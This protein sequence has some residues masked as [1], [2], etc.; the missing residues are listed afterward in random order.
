MLVD[1]TFF[2]GGILNIEGA[3][4]N[5]DSASETN[6]AIVDSLQAFVMEYEQEYLE[7]LLG[8]ELYEKF[9]SYIE[10]G[11]EPSEK[12]WDDLIDR[13]VVKRNDGEKALSKSPIANYIYFHYLRHNHTQATITGVKADGDDGRLVS[14]ERK[15]IFAWNDMVEMNRRLVGWL[16]ENRRLIYPGLVFDEELLE[17]INPFGI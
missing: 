4:L 16:E 11:K 5:T 15:M 13:L 6:R 8:E 14:P 10:N 12:R 1:Y 2:Q 7:K 17:T 9:S 3:V